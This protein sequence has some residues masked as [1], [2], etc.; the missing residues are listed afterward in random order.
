MVTLR[1]NFSFRQKT[2]SLAN[3]YDCLKAKWEHLPTTSRFNQSL[4]YWW[5]DRRDTGEWV[6]I[7]VATTSGASLK[8]FWQVLITIIYPL[9]DACAIT[10]LQL[11]NA[12][13]TVTKLICYTLLVSVEYS[14]I[15]VGDTLHIVH[16]LDLCYTLTMFRSYVKLHIE[17][18]FE[19]FTYLLFDCFIFLPFCS[20]L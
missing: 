7:R 16:A 12:C 5:H 1:I 18:L 2:A 9:S 15:H 3:H 14:I 13:I 19:N 6:L 8:P 10:M 17:S 20:V 4:H 11:Y